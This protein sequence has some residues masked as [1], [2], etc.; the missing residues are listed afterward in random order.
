MY[1]QKY[2]ERR[3]FSWDERKSEAN[4]ADRGFDKERVAHEEAVEAKDPEPR[5]RGP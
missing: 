4:L 2:A 1:I 3:L 5:P